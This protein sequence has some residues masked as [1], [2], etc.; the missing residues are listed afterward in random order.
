MT[1]KDR[2]LM[3]ALCVAGS[4]ATTLA[5][6]LFLGA[7][8]AAEPPKDLKDVVRTKRLEVYDEQ[9][10]MRAVIGT[11][12][13]TAC[14]SV[15]LIDENGKLRVVVGHSPNEDGMTLLDP[16]G[17]MRAVVA[18]GTFG[19][20]VLLRDEKGKLRSTLAVETGKE[21]KLTFYDENEEPIEEE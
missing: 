3:G 12:P 14:P 7:P 6:H 8:L 5:I 9:D 17:K 16:K 1:R 2:I 10:R 4:A 21:G 13:D 18:W 15:V 11:S 20:A 19:S